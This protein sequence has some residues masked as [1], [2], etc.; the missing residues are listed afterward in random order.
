MPRRRKLSTVFGERRD[1]NGEVTF[2]DKIK[3][4]GEAELRDNAYEPVVER[5]TGRSEYKR[6]KRVVGYRCVK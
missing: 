1:I 4:H 6:C 3:V 2:T 5:Q